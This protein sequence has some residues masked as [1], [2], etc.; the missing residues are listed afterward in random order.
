[1]KICSISN[2]SLSLCLNVTRNFHCITTVSQKGNIKLDYKGFCIIKVPTFQKESIKITSS[3]IVRDLIS[4]ICN[5]YFYWRWSHY[6]RTFLTM[7]KII[8]VTHTFQFE[9][10]CFHQLHFQIGIM[11]FSTYPNLLKSWTYFHVPTY[12]RNLIAH[13]CSILYDYLLIHACSRN[14]T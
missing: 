8:E 7:P 5:H 9:I 2:H 1:M 12:V 10:H 3:G 14:I 11:L 13:D 4:N 6:S